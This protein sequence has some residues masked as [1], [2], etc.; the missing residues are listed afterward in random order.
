MLSALRGQYSEVTKFPLKISTL[1]YINFTHVKL[2]CGSVLVR[3]WHCSSC[4]FLGRWFRSPSV[5]DTLD[6]Y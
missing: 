5:S 1:Q 3:F 4:N 6:I 2:G